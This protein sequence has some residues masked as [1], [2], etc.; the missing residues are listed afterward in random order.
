MQCV[1]L[2]AEARR[3]LPGAG[4]SRARIPAYLP[5]D[6]NRRTSGES[7]QRARVSG[8]W[9][10]DSK[11]IACSSLVQRLL[12]GDDHCSVRRT[13]L[14]INIYKTET[15]RINNMKGFFSD[16]IDISI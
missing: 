10:Q 5:R 4:S 3:R 9:R 15:K 16:R 8:P 6:F 12:V 7:G 14:S 11:H 1:A 13:L 2:T